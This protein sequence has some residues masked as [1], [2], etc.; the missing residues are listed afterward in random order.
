[1]L[2]EELAEK[3]STLEAL[4]A[5][6]DE[7]SW[8]ADYIALMFEADQRYRA[9]LVD[10][11][12]NGAT[13]GLKDFKQVIRHAD[14]DH[15]RRLQL[16]L[17]GRSWPSTSDYSS[18]TCEHA[19]MIALHADNDIEFQEQVLRAMS[20][21]LKAGTLTA[22]QY[23]ALY[24]RIAIGKGQPQRYGMFYKVEGGEELDYP[25]ESPEQL[26]FRR[27]ELGLDD[28]RFRR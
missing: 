23:A 6:P 14:Q 27:A 24:D 12:D 13:S 11:L 7:V 22:V 9:L 2:Q 19:W 16:W 5:R 3:W 17:A 28:T 1:M 10:M 15:Q 8:F 21:L 20:P 18:E 4:E 26:T 25:T